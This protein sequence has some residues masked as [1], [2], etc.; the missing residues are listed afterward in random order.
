[1]PCGI[2]ARLISQVFD[3]DKFGEHDELGSYDFNMKKVVEE[4]RA[5]VMCV[6]PCLQRP[7]YGLPTLCL[8]Y[9]KLRTQ[10]SDTITVAPPGSCCGL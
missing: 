6:H 2:C 3:W 1:M 4:C 10:S 8:R 5:D 7:P 9:L